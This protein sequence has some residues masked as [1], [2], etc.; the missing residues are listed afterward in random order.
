MIDNNNNKKSPVISGFFLFEFLLFAI[1]GI[2]RCVYVWERVCFFSSSLFFQYEQVSIEYRMISNYFF[3]DSISI[4]LP[5]THSIIIHSAAHHIFQSMFIYI[6]SKCTHTNMQNAHTLK[7]VFWFWNMVS[8]IYMWHAT[9]DTL[10][11]LC[12]CECKKKFHSIIFKTPPPSS[13]VITYTQLVDSDDRRR[14]RWRRQRRRKKDIK[15]VMCIVTFTSIITTTVAIEINWHL[16]KS[17][18]YFTKNTHLFDLFYL[19]GVGIILFVFL[20]LKLLRLSQEE[21]MSHTVNKCA[22]KFSVSN[23]LFT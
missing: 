5:L 23:F 17:C 19:F 3:L 20:I 10:F 16:C 4:P 13:T 9:C 21:K 7:F 2:L 1:V 15:L 22:A 12:L 18:T 6:I 11:A 14:W 8:V